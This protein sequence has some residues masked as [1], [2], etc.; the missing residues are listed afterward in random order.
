MVIFFINLFLLKQLLDYNSIKNNSL[1]SIFKVCHFF[2]TIQ[3]GILRSSFYTPIT[4]LRIHSGDLRIHSG[5]LRIHSG[6]LRTHSGDLRKSSGG[7]RIQSGRV[8]IHS[9]RVRIH[10]G[11]VRKSSGGFYKLCYGNN[12]NFV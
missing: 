8:R 11:N 5:D 7:F 10:S 4:L 1:P 3:D 6:D 12:L 9:G 2:W